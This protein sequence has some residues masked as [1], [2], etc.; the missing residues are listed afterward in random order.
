M[1]EALPSENLVEANRNKTRGVTTTLRLHTKAITAALLSV[2]RL[3]KQ[4]LE[5]VSRIG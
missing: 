4:V 2:V 1:R 3:F 5:V